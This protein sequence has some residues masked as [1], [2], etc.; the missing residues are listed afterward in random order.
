V[1][2]R[3]IPKTLRT[4]LGYWWKTA[5]LGRVTIPMTKLPVP[6]PKI[7]Q[8]VAEEMHAA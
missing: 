4:L 1:S 2:L 8:E 6:R 7:A 5:V 3:E